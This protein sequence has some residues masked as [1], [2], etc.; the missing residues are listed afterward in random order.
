MLSLSVE[1][2]GPVSRSASGLLGR[3]LVGAVGRARFAFTSFR[4]WQLMIT[5]YSTSLCTDTTFSKA[6]S[7]VTFRRSLLGVGMLHGLFAWRP[8]PITLSSDLVV[9]SLALDVNCLCRS[10]R[11]GVVGGMDD[12]ATGIDI[13]GIRFRFVEANELTIKDGWVKPFTIQN[14]IGTP[15][16]VPYM[17]QVP[18]SDGERN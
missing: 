11:G 17:Y 4:G 15:T 6:S 14:R 5:K 16:T 3:G 10:A 13:S 7:T 1:I 8:L 18:T 9:L 2:I 12:A